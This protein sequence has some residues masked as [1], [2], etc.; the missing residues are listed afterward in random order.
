MNREPITRIVTAGWSPLGSHRYMRQSASTDVHAYYVERDGQWVRIP[1]ESTVV[2]PVT[3][4][5]VT[6]RELP[7]E[8]ADE[9]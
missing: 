2:H 1:A 5:H 8:E 3:G 9:S 6:V 4:E 7:W